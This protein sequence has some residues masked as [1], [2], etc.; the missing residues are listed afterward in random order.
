MKA[1][2]LNKIVREESGVHTYT[3]VPPPRQL[4]DKKKE[5]EPVDAE[6][7]PLFRPYALEAHQKPVIMSFGHRPSSA[8]RTFNPATMRVRLKHGEIAK[9]ERPNASGFGIPV[10]V[11]TKVLHAPDLPRPGTEFEAPSPSKSK[12]LGPLE[13]PNGLFPSETDMESLGINRRKGK[14]IS[15]SMSAP[16]NTATAGTGVGTGA[17]ASRGGQSPSGRSRSAHSRSS[18]PPQSPT[19]SRLSP[20]S[21]VSI[22]TNSTK[23]SK[24]EKRIEKKDW[25]DTCTLQEKPIERLRMKLSVINPKG[26]RSISERLNRCAFI[27]HNSGHIHW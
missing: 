18:S 13:D 22:I 16:S 21:K 10:A 6:T 8:S 27:V 19:G 23:R 15:K 11:L 7:H 20:Y 26:E 9:Q 17:S 24:S 1:K 5:V 14:K 2:V 25:D 4:D 12:S 3:L